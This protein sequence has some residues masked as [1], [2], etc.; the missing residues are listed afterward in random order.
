[1]AEKDSRCEWGHLWRR[2]PL[3]LSQLPAGRAHLEDPRS[4]LF[5]EAVRV[6]DLV[7]EVADA[8]GMWNIRFLENAV[9]DE[10]EIRTMSW[11]LAMKPL[12]VDSRHLSRARRPRLFWVS[13]P[14][15]TPRRSL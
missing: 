15:V 9:P 12:L 6:M 3:G 1:M 14:L 8:E 2:Q 13:V 5:Y 4:A 11:A 7:K 10:E